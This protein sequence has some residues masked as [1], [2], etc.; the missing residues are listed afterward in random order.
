MIASMINQE[1]QRQRQHLELIAS[2][3]FTSPAVIEAVGSIL[4]NK[5]AEG[6]PQKRYYGGCQFVDQI[7]SVAIERARQL[8]GCEHVNVQP[9]SGSQANTAVYMACLKPGDKILTMS[10]E[11]GGHL[12]HGYVKNISGML[13][14]V[15][16][17]GISEQ[18]GA[19]D[20]DQLE[21]LAKTQ[22]PKMITI[23]ASAHSRQI[24][25][26]RVGEIAHRY[27][28]LLMADIAHIAGLVAVGLHPSPVPHADFVTTTTHKT[29][30]GPRGGMILCKKE[31][32]KAIDSAVFPG[33]QG[34]PLMHVIAGKAVCFLEAL[35][36]EFKAYQEQILSNAKVLCEAMKARGYTIVSGKT[37]NHLFLIDLRP[38]FSEISGKEA[39]IALEEANITLNKNTVPHET[40]SPFEGSGLRVGVPAVTTR[41]M[42]EEEMLKIATFM[43][44]V[45]RNIRDKTTIET[46][47]QAV[48]ALCVRFPLPY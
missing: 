34:G 20:Y 32:G 7:E 2:E 47:R 25:F 11:H 17:Y 22:R 28:A 15:T 31:F 16:H 37:E 44:S 35:Q 8:F 4:T 45:L 5:Y 3:N 39:Q 48:I 36:D 33:T 6:Y 14:D 24:D 21:F 40:R 26:G 38:T 30:R 27:E 18:T 42:K 43:D 23:G 13:F 1:L 41:G 19:I 29:L 9:H 10:L 12:T 46:I